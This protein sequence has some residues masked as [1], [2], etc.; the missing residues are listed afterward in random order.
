MG[1]LKRCSCSCYICASQFSRDRRWAPAWH[2]VGVL[3]KLQL[4]ISRS[5]LVVWP[6]V[7][8]HPWRLTTPQ[9]DPHLS[10]GLNLWRTLHASRWSCQG[11]ACGGEATSPGLMFGSLSSSGCCCLSGFSLRHAA[12]NR[13][14]TTTHN[15]QT[16]LISCFKAASE[17]AVGP[18]STN[19]QVMIQTWG[20]SSAFVRTRFHCGFHR[21]FSFHSQP[22]PVAHVYG[23]RKPECWGLTRS[24]GCPR[25]W[26]RPWPSTFW[27][28]LVLLG[29]ET[30][31]LKAWSLGSPRP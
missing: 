28:S 4:K 7:T 16:P 14:C 11:L 13:R 19:R 8:P 27:V 29:E 5:F 10:L 23:L 18:V 3:L 21:F 26:N 17:C 31:V 24:R 6:W 25:P 9:L 15:R 12:F 20:L 22:S 30:E 1:S 2:L